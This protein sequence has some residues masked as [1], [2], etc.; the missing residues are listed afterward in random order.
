MDRQKTIAKEVSINGVGIHTAH[1]VNITFRP[2]KVDSG[3]NFLR[4]DLA[5]TPLIK[6]SIEYL[7]PQG[8]SMRRTS[9]GKDNIQ[10]HTIEHLMAALSGLDIDNILIE[11]DNNEIPGM[12]G[13]SREFLEILS[14]AGVVEQ[15]KPRQ[16]YFLKE[17]IFVEED[18]ASIVAIPSQDFKISYILNYNHP[19]LKI[20]FMEI[21]LNGNIFKDE[22][23]SARTFC[24]EDEA[25]RLREQGLGGGATY[26]NTIVVGKSGII[27]N[28]LRYENEFIRH[29][30]LDLVGD[31]FLLGQPIRSHIIALRSGHALNLKLL[32][33]IDQQRQRYSL[34]GVGIGYHPG[35]EGEL[36]REAIMKILP[37]R[38]PFLFVD[39]IISLKQG[40]YAVGIK[41]VTKDEYFFKGHFPGKPVMPGVLIIE[42]MAQVGGVMMLSPEENRGKLAYFLAADNIKF[43]KTVVPGDQLLLRVE[44]DKIKSKTGRVHGKALVDGKV[45]SEADMMFALVEG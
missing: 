11:I 30:I 34:G 44:A 7:L 6:A 43:R 23:A 28:K 45:V 40:K 19:L 35:E 12:D 33:K 24:L 14:Q 22:L 4:T 41:N 38:P 1:K 31:L 9:L 21:N 10:I 13:S 8:S 29:K 17:P 27:K 18:D 37:H 32:K 2:A 3:I 36:D 16:Y 5:S 42:A 39:K 26:D 25:S 15:E 20:E